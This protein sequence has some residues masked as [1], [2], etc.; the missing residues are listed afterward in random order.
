MV[1]GSWVLS[2][3]A[4]PFRREPS[5]IRPAHRCGPA[6]DSTPTVKA[7]FVRRKEEYGMWWP[8]AVYNGEAARKDFQA[9]MKAAAE[10]RRM[11]LQIRPK[12]IY[13]MEEAEI[14]LKKAQAEKADGLMLILLDRQQHSWPTARR[15][16]EAGIPLV[17]FSP[18][19]SSFTTNTA[20]LTGKTGYVIYSA[21]EFDQGIYGLR[22]LDTGARLRHTRCVVL[23]GD[24]TADRKLGGL[25]VSLR[26]VPV[27]NYV[28]EF[29]EV[30]V[31]EEARTLADA[32]VS[33]ARLVD[34]PS[35]KDLVDGARAYL[36]ARNIL[37]WEQGDAITM[38]CLGM[39]RVHRDVNLP[40]LAWA[41]LNDQGV[42]AACE[43]DLGAVASHILVQYLFERPGF[44]QDPVA[45][46]THEAV[47]GAH[48][49]CPTRLEGFEKDREPFDLRHHHALR[50]VTAR[51]IWGKG[52]RV[53]SLDVYPGNG[54]RKT[55]MEIATGTVLSNLKVPPNGG[56]VVSVR[57]KFD[58]DQE[59]RTFPGF[60]QLWFYGDYGDHLEEFCQL[61]GMKAQ[62]V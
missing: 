30:G 34:G 47:I 6:A 53:T 39:G 55:R 13:S 62:R 23:K 54:N 20:P 51:T 7:A 19:G 57:V 50:D 2:G 35:R 41:H 52:Q 21:E 49:S 3:C 18:V 22:M 1:G 31:T 60:H 8:G 45:D 15:A 26:Y 28:K 42:P 56:C 58:G 12:P 9:Q 29:K 36:A 4:M 24:S 43:A 48:C 16:T 14:W 61:F 59:V 17:I 11:N 27:N 32:F 40:C 38:D 46:T 44:Q 37:E 33:Q 10:A 25:G 5:A